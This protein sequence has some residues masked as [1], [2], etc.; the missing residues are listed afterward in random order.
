MK[1]MLSI[2]MSVALLISAFSV[3]FSTFAATDDF[4]DNS[5]AEAND[6][7]GAAKACDGHVLG[8]F[9]GVPACVNENG[10]LH[11]CENNFPDEIFRDY[12][13]TSNGVEKYLTKNMAELV[14]LITLV[15]EKFYGTKSLKGIEYFDNLKTLDV[16]Y[17]NL[18]ILNLKNNHQL[19][20]LDCRSNFELKKIDVTGCGE[21][22]ELVIGDALELQELDIS[23]NHKLE[24][25]HCTYTGI[26]AIDVS[27]NPE[28]KYITSMHSQLTEIDVSNNYKLEELDVFVNK[29]KSLDITKN[30]NL[31]SLCCDSNELS[32]LDVSHNY[33]LEELYAGR[34]NL[35]NIDVTNNKNLL[36]LQVYG[37]NIKCIDVSNNTQLRSLSVSDNQLETLDVSENM[38]LEILQCHNN[39]LKELNLEANN[40]LD[41]LTCYNN[42]LSSLNIENNINLRGP[43]Y[44]NQ[45]ISTKIISEG[46]RWIVDMNAILPDPERII[47]VSE[48]DY[49][50]KTGIVTFYEKPDYFTYEYDVGGGHDPMTVTV[51]PLESIL[52]SVEICNW[53][54][55]TKYIQG[56]ETFDPAGGKLKLNFNDGT[57]S[58][59]D[60]TDDM[61]TGFDNTQIGTQA[62]TIKYGDYTWN[63]EVEIVPYVENDLNSD[64]L[65]TSD[66]ATYLLYHV[67]YP[68][69][70]PLRQDCDF[71]KDGSVTSDDATYL[72][73]HVFYPDDYPLVSKLS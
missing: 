50:A 30:P 44:Q 60:I 62:L 22:K 68:A 4:S 19:E 18:V 71:N 25:L 59:L 42:M 32:S 3:N 37:N 39:P 9:S 31:K 46:R 54:T 64:G 2:F 43:H 66:D 8:T 65:I 72:L 58:T 15:E 16:S 63:F 47:S 61:V 29:I 57:S 13:S 24:E 45:H 70:Y 53:P 6:E 1:K 56:R 26:K 12:I 20:N 38:A 34:N 5:A 23:G 48:G 21:L 69:D 28:L 33:A 10:E 14:T 17:N 36:H 49:N 40:K 52:S 41:L 73:Y 11:I 51:E 55:K 27:N 67:F 35:D 7:L